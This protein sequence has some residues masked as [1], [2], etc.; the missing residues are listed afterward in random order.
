MMTSKKVEE[1]KVERRT[2]YKVNYSYVVSSSTL[3][4]LFHKKTVYAYLKDGKI[5]Y[6][7]AKPN[8]PVSYRV[9]ESPR[10]CYVKKL[11]ANL[12]RSSL[13]VTIPKPFV[14]KLNIKEGQKVDIVVRKDGFIIIP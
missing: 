2:V 9:I 1:K 11:I 3:F 10:V 5:V 8:L 12:K 13:L 7:L 6:S 4:K 14:D